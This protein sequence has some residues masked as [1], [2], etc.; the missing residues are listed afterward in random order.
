MHVQYI[1]SIDILVVSE[2]DSFECLLRGDLKAE[3]ES[4]TTAA[5]D[6]TIETKYHTIKY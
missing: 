4:G 5:H 6:K 3:I 1:R 2:E